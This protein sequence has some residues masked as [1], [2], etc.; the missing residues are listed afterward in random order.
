MDDSALKN[1]RR[2]IVVRT[3][4]DRVGRFVQPANSTWATDNGIAF[5][6]DAT[7][8]ATLHTAANAGS[9]PSHC[10]LCQ[11]ASGDLADSIGSWT[12]ADGGTVS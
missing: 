1:R 5:P 2:R 9:P 7:Q 6:A 11:E 12:L 10:H 8:W 3:N 4:R